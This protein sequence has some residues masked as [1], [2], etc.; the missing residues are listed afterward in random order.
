MFCYERKFPTRLL[1]EREL[2]VIVF[3]SVYKADLK[4]VSMILNDPKMFDLWKQD[5]QTM[6][7]RI[8]RLYSSCLRADIKIETH[9]LTCARDCSSYWP[10][11]IRLRVTGTIS[12]SK[13]ACKHATS[14]Y[15]RRVW[16]TESQV[17]IHRVGRDFC[18]RL[19]CWSLAACSYSLN[20]PSLPFRRLSLT[21][22]VCS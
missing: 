13:L 17:L 22:I 12:L 3:R 7:H 21:D 1:S 11:H 16:H 15:A 9:R 5:I 14:V 18:F 8:V 4:Q 2:L 10:R 19:M 6:A 20:R